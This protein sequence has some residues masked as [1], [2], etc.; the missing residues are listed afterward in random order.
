MLRR[1]ETAGFTFKSPTFFGLDWE[2]IVRLND[3][4][5]LPMTDKHPDM[6]PAFVPVRYEVNRETVQ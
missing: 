1:H 5:F 4:G 2:D 3:R 6:I